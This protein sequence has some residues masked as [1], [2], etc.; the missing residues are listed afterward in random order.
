MK[1]DEVMLLPAVSNVE[2]SASFMHQS[3]RRINRGALEQ[4]V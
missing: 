1:R 3:S 2:I 4:V